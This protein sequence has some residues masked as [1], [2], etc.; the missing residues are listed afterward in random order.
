MIPVLAVSGFKKSGKTTLCRELAACF[1]EVGVR[2]GF[3]KRTH[4]P[5]IG[6][7][8]TDTGLLLEAGVPTL[9]WASDGLRAENREQQ[10]E[11][12]WM[13]ERFMPDVDLV[14]LEGGK[15]LSLPRVWVGNPEECPAEVK[16]ILAWFGD[17]QPAGRI[18]SFRPG[19]EK[20]LAAYIL[21]RFMGKKPAPSVSLHVD[22][23]RIPLKPYL[24]AFLGQAILGMIRSLKGTHGRDISIHIRN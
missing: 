1:Q 4:E 3:V 16:G 11:L 22:G 6:C 10:P 7:R 12:D 18:P 24:E 5:S 19:Q 21:D 9:L 23:R 2:V 14:L 20:E 13:V 17:F 8:G 15:N